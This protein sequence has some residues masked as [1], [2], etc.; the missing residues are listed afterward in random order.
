MCCTGPWTPDPSVALRRCSPLLAN[1]NVEFK[2]RNVG[3]LCG[4]AVAQILLV[5][6]C[7]AGLPKSHINAPPDSGAA[8]YP[9][10][11][12]QGHFYGG[13]DLHLLLLNVW[14]NT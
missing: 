2:A 1:R 5:P 10:H 11:K 3:L 7:Q 8:W 12:E 13:H 14:S 4:G 9:Y 6:S